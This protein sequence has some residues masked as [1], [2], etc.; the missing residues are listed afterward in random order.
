MDY[1]W[2]FLLAGFVAGCSSMLLGA[3]VI[4]VGSVGGYRREL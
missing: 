4:V 1:W 2:L 3:V